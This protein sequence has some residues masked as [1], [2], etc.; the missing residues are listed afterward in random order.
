M[1]RFKNV[2]F[3]LNNLKVLS[4]L[5]DVVKMQFDE[6]GLRMFCVDKSVIS[7]S[8]FA[9]K[10]EFFEEFYTKKA[11]LW[12]DINKLIAVLKRVKDEC[13]VFEP[14]QKALSI[15]IEKGVWKRVFN[16]NADEEEAFEIP[17]VESMKYD[18]CLIAETDKISKMLSDASLISDAITLKAESNMLNCFVKSVDDKY[19]TTIECEGNMNAKSKYAL[20]YMQIAFCNEICRTY[21]HAKLC[22]KDNF[23]LKA[24]F[25]DT[26]IIYIAPRIDEE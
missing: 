15:T 13:V 19:E 16:I 14:K 1:I 12:I 11:T 6:S 20:D 5:N 8:V 21:P 4:K 2:K 17:N 7:L 9:L 22:F 23:P 18:E 26:L 24:I 25:N 10:P 3:V